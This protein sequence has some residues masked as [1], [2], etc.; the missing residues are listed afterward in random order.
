MTRKEA[1]TILDKLNA[2]IAAYP[3]LKLTAK[4]TFSEDQLD[5]GKIHP[6]ITLQNGSVSADEQAD[7]CKEY[8]IPYA[9]YSDGRF[10]DSSFN[11]LS[12]ED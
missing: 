2:I 4:V 11:Q 6:F 3:E 12:F 8:N 7:F 9:N 1:N 10:V 5:K